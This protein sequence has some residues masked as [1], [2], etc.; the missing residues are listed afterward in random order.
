MELVKSHTVY[1]NSKMRTTGSTTDD[2]NISLRQPLTLVNSNNS[3]RVRME[4]CVIPHCIKQ[5]S[6]NNNVLSFTYIRDTITYNSFITLTSGNYTILTLNDELK[7][8]LAAKILSLSSI[9]VSLTF[10]YDRTTG[11]DTFNITGTDGVA[12]SI[13]LLFSS[14]VA[15]GKFFGFIADSQFRYNNLNVSFS[16]TSTQNV[17]VNQ[18]NSIYIRSSSLVQ[19]E[20]YENIVERDV[21]SD[22][23]AQ[24]PI[25]VLPGNFIFFTNDGP[26][27]DIKNNIIDSINIYLSDNNSY[28]LSLNGLDWS[29]VLIFE[30]WGTTEPDKILQELMPTSIP[31]NTPDLMKQLDELKSKLQT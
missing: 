20:C 9:V 13:T 27:L 23:I 1:I 15:L 26:T 22:I 10:S 3:F 4:Q 28:T 24:V 2:F 11:L 7:A 31:D 16:S 6:S 8:K 30:E 17:N 12:S 19:R 5:I 14:N 18:I 21:Y 25:T 29:C